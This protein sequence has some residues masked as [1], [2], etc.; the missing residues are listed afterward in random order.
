MCAPH[1]PDELP[2]R[3]PASRALPTFRLHVAA[4]LTF[5]ATLW[6]RWP[7]TMWAIPLQQLDEPILVLVT[8][9]T[10]SSCRCLPLAGMR[11]LPSPEMCPLMTA[12][13]TP[14]VELS[15][16]M[17]HPL[18]L[19]YFLKPLLVLV[20]STFLFPVL[21]TPRNLDLLTLSSVVVPPTMLDICLFVPM[22]RKFLVPSR[23]DRTVV[24]DDVGTRPC[25]RQAFGHSAT[26]DEILANVLVDPIILVLMRCP[27]TSDGSLFREMANLMDLHFRLSQLRMEQAL[28]LPW[29]STVCNVSILKNLLVT[30][31]MSIVMITAS[32]TT[33][34]WWW[35]PC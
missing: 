15:F 5:S 26:F 24:M 1:P 14:R 7:R 30:I 3:V 13:R 32:M 35:I 10:T 34:P 12:P 2:S 25:S 19:S 11:T 16:P 20:G 21:T 29:L 31:M 28:L 23:L 27:V 6:L 17:L 4:E 33:A 9:V 8:E 22:L 18:G